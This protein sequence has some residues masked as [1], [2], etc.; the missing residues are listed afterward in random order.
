MTF[1]RWCNPPKLPESFLRGSFSLLNRTSPSH[2]GVLGR[3][4]PR[5]DGATHF[6]VA[7][8]GA[9]RLRT[10]GLPLYDGWRSE[11]A[12]GEARGYGHGAQ[13]L[14]FELAATS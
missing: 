4:R 7:H 1:Q 3:A 12:E 10:G 8:T 11:L 2:L 13:S 5:F 9:L 6:T 14:V